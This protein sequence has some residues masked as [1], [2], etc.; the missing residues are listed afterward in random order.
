M[1]DDLRTIMPNNEHNVH[2]DQPSSQE[3]RVSCNE[4]L[5][6]ESTHNLQK[7]RNEKS[8][9]NADHNYAAKNNDQ[10]PKDETVLPT[11][12]ITTS[13]LDSMIKALLEQNQALINVYKREISRSIVD[14]V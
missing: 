8:N 1:N 7:L 11:Q 14:I 5:D 3:S 4:K 2:G 6:T 12:S 10:S 13:G 9:Q